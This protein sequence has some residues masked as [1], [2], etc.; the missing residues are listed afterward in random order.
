M[1][2][3]LVNKAVQVSSVQLCNIGCHCVA[4]SPPG[5]RPLA[6][7]FPPYPFHRPLPLAVA[8]LMSV[9]AFVLFW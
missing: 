8:I 2:V 4:C 9:S 5:A 1:A 3:T 6:A 7:T